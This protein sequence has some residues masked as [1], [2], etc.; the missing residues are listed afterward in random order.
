MLLP[1]R[2]DT[3][4]QAALLNAASNYFLIEGRVAFGKPKSKSTKTGRN[5]VM[6]VGLNCYTERFREMNLPGSVSKVD[7]RYTLRI[8]EEDVESGTEERWFLD[9]PEYIPDDRSDAVVATMAESSET[10]DEEKEDAEILHREQ[11]LRDD[12]FIAEGRAAV[13]AWRVEQDARKQK[14][15]R[16]RPQS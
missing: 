7:K 14:T 6:I 11:R 16:K 9:E 2:P 10:T 1:V 12:A 3:D 13:D 15:K 4:Y 8:V 5:P